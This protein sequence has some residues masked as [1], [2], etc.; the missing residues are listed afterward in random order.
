MQERRYKI[1]ANRQQ[2]MIMP[3]KIKDYVSETNLVRAI[4]VYVDTLDMA[5]LGFAYTDAGSA[6]GG[7]PAYPPAS[8]LKL[9]LYG[10]ENKIRFSRMLEREAARNVEMMWLLQGFTPSHA[11]IA[12]FRK[13]NLK[14]MKNVNRDFVRLCR[15]LDLF[16]REEVS[17]DGTFMRGNAS[18]A[19][20]HTQE[21][22]EKQQ[23]KLTQEIEKIEKYFAELDE[24]ACTHHCFHTVFSAPMP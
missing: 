21:K 9:Y 17:I 16:G 2:E 15:E 18:K 10:Y 5:A 22:L 6:L 19:R 14:T 11:S 4:D 7:Q 8:M 23:P 13:N 24:I 1:G 20:I 3:P 12:N